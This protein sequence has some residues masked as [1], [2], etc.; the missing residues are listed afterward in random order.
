MSHVSLLFCTSSHITEAPCSM[1]SL[2]N[3]HDTVSN[4]VSQSHHVVYFFT[5]PSIQT[6]DC[7]TFVMAATTY[8]SPWFH[9]F[10][11]II[12]ILF[13]SLITGASKY[14]ILSALGTYKCIVRNFTS[15]ARKENLT[16]L[17]ISSTDTNILSIPFLYLLLSGSTG[18]CAI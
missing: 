4:P 17:Q 13:T 8:T 9:V 7:A 3:G 2:R 18:C 1:S 12:M 6:S 11:L 10:L 14:G 5:Q 16:N 15:N